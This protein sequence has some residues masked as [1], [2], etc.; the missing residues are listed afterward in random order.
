MGS[1]RRYHTDRPPR[2]EIWRSPQG[3]TY[4]RYVFPDGQTRGLGSDRAQA[5][6]TA[7]A[8]NAYFDAEAQ[9]QAASPAPRR[10]ARNPLLSDAIEDFAT[11][12]VAKRKY[13]DRSRKEIAYRLNAYKARWPRATVQEI[14]VADL[15]DFLNEC[16]PHTYPKHRVQLGQLFQFFA[17]QGW[18]ASNIAAQTMPAA[19]A[20]GKVRQRHTLDGFNEILNAGTT[21]DWLRRAMRLGLYTL[22]RESDIV[23]L[24]RDD[25]VD[26]AALLVTQ[27]KTLNYANPV[28]LKIIMEGEAQE[29]L[30]ACL[31]TGIPCPNLIHRRPA[32][33]TARKKASKTHPFAVQAKYLSKAFSAARDACGA[34]SHL[35]PAQRPTF[36]EIRALG[37][38][39]YR[40]QGF[41]DEYIMALSGHADAK[42]LERYDS[43]HAVPA[44]TVRAGLKI[45]PDKT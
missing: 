28:R 44:R 9:R 34:Y 3:V 2:V 16:T 36:H 4:Y 30:R 7:E 17:S 5:F 39:L 21:P 38:H 24:M 20:P 33:I 22:Q 26:G 42:M 1:K 14:A 41:S 31:T 19:E 40:E 43:D 11:R 45:A 23:S 10:S 15:S 13:S 27:A 18:I 29:A 6:S 25:V 37:I 32:R 35:S 12:W 8:L